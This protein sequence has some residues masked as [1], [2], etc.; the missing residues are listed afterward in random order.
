MRN[1]GDILEATNRSK[2]AGFHYIIFWEGHDE[3]NFIGS[4]ITTSKSFDENI[5]MAADYFIKNSLSGEVYKIPY[6][7]SLLVP[8]KLVKPQEWG[9]FSLVGKLSAKGIEFVSN[10]IDSLEPIYWR[11]KIND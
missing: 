7:P 1:K 5:P 3:S 2:E 4:I 10:N 8:C 6:K 9:P 11:E